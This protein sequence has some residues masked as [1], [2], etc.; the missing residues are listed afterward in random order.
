MALRADGTK[1][2][3][4]PGQR[5]R[6]SFIS[7][8]TCGLPS[9]SVSISLLSKQSSNSQ[10]TLIS[11]VSNKMRTGFP[12]SECQDI[13]RYEEVDDIRNSEVEYGMQL[14]CS[15]LGQMDIPNTLDEFLEIDNKCFQVSAALMLGS[16][17]SVPCANPNSQESDTIKKNTLLSP[18][19]PTES[20]TACFPIETVG[21]LSSN[22][23][24]CSWL[25]SFAEFDEVA[26][27]NAVNYQRHHKSRNDSNN[28][29]QQMKFYAHLTEIVEQFLCIAS[30]SSQFERE[31][32]DS[33]ELL[34]FAASE[35][36][37]AGPRTIAQV[38]RDRQKALA[39][40]AAAAQAQSDQD[41]SYRGS[42]IV[43]DE[44]CTDSEDCYYSVIN[45][46]DDIEVVDSGNTPD[47]AADS[48]T[49]ASE[50]LSVTVPNSCQDIADKETQ[51][52]GV[53]VA[54]VWLCRWQD[55][56]RWGM[57]SVPHIP[58]TN[59]SNSTSDNKRDPIDCITCGIVFN[60]HITVTKNT[61]DREQRVNVW[62]KIQSLSDETIFV[63]VDAMG[64]G[65]NTVQLNYSNESSFSQDES[66]NQD[67]L[68]KRNRIF[69]VDK[70]KYSDL[71][72][73]PRCEIIIPFA[74]V[75]S[76]PGVYDLS[77]FSVVAR[78]ER[79]MAN[80]L[81]THSKVKMLQQCLL[82]VD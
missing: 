61:F 1:E 9:M 77:S 65:V 4:G 50:G 36:D 10:F 6:T 26:T 28:N 68:I 14:R 35:A 32:Q 67:G 22:H 41:I 13:S 24:K 18:V 46:N 60:H 56:I 20:L 38:R 5:C 37:N 48:G 69:W 76:Q 31:V 19:G 71:K 23:G 63:T 21:E 70:I 25:V 58:L 16:A 74:L 79:S 78:Y 7:I 11:E 73:S 34:I 54:F 45:L 55:K 3:F 52:L 53:A 57:E 43:T 66:I 47:A 17:I 40:K 81:H 33:R 27:A 15:S 64:N 8:Q 42:N 75:V 82:Q 29:N 2:P 39:A 12:T 44:G 30:A 51:S 59:L 80:S 49:L 72:L 62:M